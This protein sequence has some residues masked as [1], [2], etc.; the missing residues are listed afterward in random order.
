MCVCVFTCLCK[1]EHEQLGLVE[2]LSC[3]VFTASAGYFSTALCSSQLNLSLSLLLLFLKPTPSNLPFPLPCQQHDSVRK[4]LMLGTG[5][6]GEVIRAVCPLMRLA[7]AGWQGPR[8]Q[9]QFS[10]SSVWYF[11][12]GLLLQLGSKISGKL[13]CQLVLPPHWPVFVC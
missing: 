13:P 4:A 8:C 5:H 6:G 10:G 11:I 2:G 3:L 12:W 1:S 7:L 9:C